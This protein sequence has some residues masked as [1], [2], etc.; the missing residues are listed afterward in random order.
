MY[1]GEVGHNKRSCAKKKKEDAEEQTRQMQ[2]QLAL[3]K[4][5]VPPTDE[6]KT[7]NEVQS[8]SLP[9]PPVQPQ[10]DVEVS[11]PKETPPMQDTQ[12]PVQDPQGAKRGK[13]PILY[14]IKSNAR[15]NASTKS[16]VAISAETLKGTTSATA[17]KMQ[18]FMTFVPTQGF[19]RPRKKE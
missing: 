6:A 16:P 9:P 11:Q 5:H 14:V 12:S 18:T 8:H 13:P 17:K 4:E 1:C 2:L 10:P 3:V 19:K 15:L 7:N